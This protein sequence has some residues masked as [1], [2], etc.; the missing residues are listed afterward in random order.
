MDR[1]YVVELSDAE[2]E[3][4]EK[5]VAAGSERARTLTRARI[6]LKTDSSA[7]GTKWT[8]A[9]ICE[10]FDVTQVT[11]SKVRKAYAEQGLAAAIQRK[12]PDREYLPRLD[13]KAEAHWVALT[14]GEPPTGQARWT[15]RLLQE[16]MVELEIVESVSHETV[17]KTL[18]KM[19]LSPG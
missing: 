9:Q 2:R 3:Q 19:N 1:K 16:K 11:V 13:G 7:A 4:L 18:K 14:C 12:Q 8:Y 10:A 17:R 15:L 6:L 5:L